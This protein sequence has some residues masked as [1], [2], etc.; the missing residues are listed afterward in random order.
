MK[1]LLVVH[2]YPPEEV[3]G[4]ETSVRNVAHGLARRGIETV[5]VAGSLEFE[6]GFRRSQGEDTDP[7]SGRAI[8]VHR[9]HRDDQHFDHWQKSASARVSRAFREILREERPDVVHVHH[10]IRLSR[11]L[12]AC[13]AREGIPSVVTLHDFWTTCLV[14]FRIRPDTEEVCGAKL[15]PQPCIDCAGLN[16][17]R[18]PWLSR[19]EQIIEL[20][21]RSRDLQRELEIASTVIV[22][23]RAH[24]RAIEEFLGLE[25][26]SLDVEV[27]PHGRDVPL[28]RHRMPPAPGPGRPLTLGAWGNLFP[29]K[30]LD[31]VLEAIRMLPDPSRVRLVVAGGETNAAYTAHLHELAEGIDVSFHPHYE[32]TSL[33]RHPVTAVH[34][35]VTG[36]RARETWG[37]VVD[38]AAA[39]G[40]PMILPRSG[41]FPD[42]VPEGAGAL[43]YTPRDPASLAR[44]I[45]C[46]VEEKGL[47]EELWRLLPPLEEICPSVDE[48]VR[49]LVG[50]YERAADEGPAEVEEEGWWGGRMQI[51]KEQEWDRQVTTLPHFKLGLRKMNIVVALHDYLPVHA[52]GSEIHAHQTARELVRRG[53]R[54]TAIFTEHDPEAEVGQVRRGELDGVTT[55]EIVHPRAYEDLKEVWEQPGMEPV[56]RSLLEE[57]GP[58]VVHFHHLAYLGSKCILA[59]RDAGAKVLLTLHD[60]HL[61]CD[62]GVL[63]RKDG[64]LCEEGPIGACS[65][66]LRDYPVIPERWVE[67]EIDPD[68]DPVGWGV[69]L[70]RDQHL[71]HLAHVHTIICP[72]RFLEKVF[73]DAGMITNQEVHVLKAGYPGERREPRDSDPGE[74]LRVGYV[75]GI[76]ESKGVHVLVEAFR[77]L[78]GR[79]ISLSIHGHLDWFPD[80]VAAL[81]DAAAGSDVTFAGPFENDEVDAVMTQFDVLVVPSIWYENMPITIQEA[82]RNAVPVV[83]TDLGGMAEVVE[84]GVTGLTFPRGDSAAL[85]GCLVRLAEDRELLARLAEARPRVP[86]LPDVVN[87]LETIYRT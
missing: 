34:A 14:I 47:V 26:G 83:A 32:V 11:D 15:A 39:L 55:L 45:W 48:H 6:Q 56:F 37:L 10:W 33:D 51:A 23:S 20:R 8:R 12:A 21:E 5:V 4:T 80:Y 30:G 60:Y 70:R 87:R 22:P 38:E 25:E 72:S 42:R 9:I 13:A 85:A 41:A 53:H 86:S 36:T 31:I 24:A 64:S 74:P 84:D 79:K 50:I 66:C 16:P 57:I 28:H 46:L 35:M 65:H 77:H 18:T 75:G 44:A 7:V 73:R 67:G 3:G 76:Y 63:L 61:I 40:L 58:D 59:A 78:R 81:R 49:E 52:G 82:Y 54:V 29:L 68:W 1:V 69:Q 2:G 27:V 71:A 62:N 17:P 19:E 43:F